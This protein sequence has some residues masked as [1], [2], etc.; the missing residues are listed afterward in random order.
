MK[1]PEYPIRRVEKSP[2]KKVEQAP[3]VPIIDIIRHGETEYKQREGGGYIEEPLNTSSPDFELNSHYLDLTDKG[4]DTMKN[5]ADQLAKMIDKDNEIVLI[6]SSPSWRAHSSGLVME[7]ELRT[8][9]INILN[10][11]GEYKFFEAL[12]EA[13][14]RFRKI[15]NK[16]YDADYNP[17]TPEGDVDEREKRHEVEALAFQQFLRHM[18]N[19]YRFLKPETIKMLKGKKLRIVA[20]THAEITNNFIPETFDIITSG[21]YQ[22]RGQILELIPKSKLRAEGS[23]RTDVRLFP[24]R[25]RDGEKGQIMRGFKPKE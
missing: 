21:D 18:N 8:K 15:H 13:A 10:K 19:V 3:N 23:S 12:N 6:V 22:K 1:V 9:G 5:T 7:Q 4:I 25:D 14:S 17:I 11:E 2:T 16:Y 24:G 20:F